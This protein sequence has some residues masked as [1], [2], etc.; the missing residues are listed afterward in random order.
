M[1]KIKLFNLCRRN[2]RKE[3]R[4]KQLFHPVSA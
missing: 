4:W 1:L 2:R 3:G